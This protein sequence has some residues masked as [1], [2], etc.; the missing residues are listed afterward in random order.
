MKVDQTREAVT[1]K[2]AEKRRWKILVVAGATIA[3][4]AGM[5]STLPSAYAGGT[6]KVD[7]DKWISLGMG[8][9]TDF[10]AAENEAANGSSF[11]NNFAI[12]S[13]RVYINGKIHKNVGFEFNTECFG[14]STTTVAAGG[15]NGTV[16]LLDAIG[17]FEFNQFVNVWVGRHLVTGER[18]E[19]NGPYYHAVYDGF[20]TPFN[21]ADSSGFGTGGGG[22]YGRSEGMTL[23]GELNPG[24]KQLQYSVQVMNGL[25]SSAGSG[26]N[27]SDNL[28]YAG[29]LT[30]NLFNPEKNP[31]YYTSGT[32]YGTAGHILAIAGGVNHQKNG[33]GS[34]ASPSDMTIFVSDLLWELP[35]GNNMDGG[36][37]TVNAE[38]KKHWADYAVAAFGAGDCFCQFRGESYTAYALYMFP[39]EIGIGKFQPYARFTSVQPESSSNREE[40]EFG[41]NYVISGH[42]ARISAFYQYGDLRSKGADFSPIASGDNISAW[43]MALQLQ[44]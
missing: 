13:A 43:K 25:R 40:T 29:R 5:V 7:D 42:N 21:S 33:A 4:V 15:E 31:G 44:Y 1:M 12:N 26:P 9:R 34:N 10:T 19:L 17:K 41:T 32:Y 27:Q 37:I 38:F 11:S 28:L 2:V 30:Y 35:L 14:C 16:G 39:G 22:K 23:W 20:K 8:I 6:I 36:V 18:G 24:G 3:L